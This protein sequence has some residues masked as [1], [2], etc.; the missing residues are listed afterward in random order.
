MNISHY[1]KA[2]IATIMGGLVILEAW[3]GWKSDFLTEE[4][5]LTVIGILTPILVFFVPNSSADE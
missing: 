2:I 5:V 1:S 3:T 4:T